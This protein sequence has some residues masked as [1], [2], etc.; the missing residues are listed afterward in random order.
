VLGSAKTRLRLR[1]PR[2]A[3]GRARD[4][5]GGTVQAGTAIRRSAERRTRGVAD[6]HQCWH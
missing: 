4:T 5:G 3:A 1:A 2:T 6:R